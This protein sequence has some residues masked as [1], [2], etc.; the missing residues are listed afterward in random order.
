M[1]LTTRRNDSDGVDEIL[2][3]LIGEI[4]SVYGQAYEE[5]RADAEKF[6]A[7]F[8]DADE[9]KRKA[10]ENGTLSAEDYKNWQRTQLLTGRTMYAKVDAIANN[11]SNVNLIALSIIN[12]YMPW[13]YATSGNWAIYDIEHNTQINTG[14]TLY[15]EAAIEKNIRENPDLLPRKKLNIPK[16]KL[17]NKQLINNAI[18]QGIIQG[19]GIEKIADRLAAVTD[20][21]RN[22]ALTNAVTMTTSAQSGGRVDTYKRAMDMGIDIKGNA[23]I[24]TLDGHTRTS[25]RKQDNMVVPVGGKFPNG[26][27]RP[28]DPNGHPS[29]VYGCRCTLV[30]VFADQDLSK[31]DRHSRLGDMSYEEWKNAKGD[32]PIFR[33]ARNAN[34]DMR[35]HEEYRKLLGNKIPKNFADFQ[36]MKYSDREQWRKHISDARKER[37]RRRKQNG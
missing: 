30:A 8:R 21:N 5:L 9:N 10:V 20:M 25:H 15:N 26:L 34:R 37:N 22:Q 18:M 14:F 24:A 27:T 32:E 17:W 35:M 7:D 19:D 6:L 12:G 13:V 28:G 23:W 33:K 11:L 2:E 36:E 1:Q 3:E 4:E 16:D 31:I 29:E